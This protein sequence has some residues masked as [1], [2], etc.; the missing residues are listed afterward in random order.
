M[1][2]RFFRLVAAAALLAAASAHS[3]LPLSMP[4]EPAVAP[5]AQAAPKLRVRPTDAVST[6]ALRVQAELSPIADVEI[7]AVR[8]ENRRAR[9]KRIAVGV[10]RGADGAA[11][12]P[13]AGDL[14]WI[15]VDGGRAAQAS[16]TSPGAASLRLAI[17]LAGVPEDVEMVFFGSRVPARLEGPIRAG[18]VKDRSKP[19][20]SPV[21]EGDTQTVEF[22]VP[23][24]RDARALPLRIVSASHL[25]S[26]P[27]DKFRKDVSDI[28]RSGSCNVDITCSPLNSNPAFRNAVEAVAQ[29]LFVDGG[30]SYSCTGTL[31]ADADTTMQAPWFYSANHC[32]DEQEPPFRSRARVQQ[33]ADT[34]TTLW[35]FEAIACRSLTPS[36]Y[37]QVPGGAAV[38]HQDPAT[39]VLFLALRAAPPAGAFYSG[40]DATPMGTGT[41]VV[42]IH[43]PAGDLKKVSQGRVLGFSTPSIAEGAA[44]G[45][46]IETIW[47][48][49]TTEFGS[50][51][52][53]LLTLANGQY[54]LRGGLF[55]GSAFC[56]QP[57]G[58]DFYSR[59]D[60]VYPILAPYLAT[61][62]P[63]GTDFTDLWWNPAE[64]GWGMNLIQHPSRNIFGVWYTYR[65]DRKAIWYVIPGVTWISSNV[66]FATVYETSGPAQ[67]G[68]FDPGR[69]RVDPVGFVLFTFTDA[70]NG[71]FAYSIDGIAGTKPITRQPF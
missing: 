12:L 8:A 65:P 47:S 54:V 43:H 14:R 16:V 48:S 56:H 31:L 9:A 33:I 71:T 68:A 69:V 45:A 20:W 44:P 27:S 1:M 62:V 59:F 67:T 10:N 34:L 35:H 19:W 37:T 2:K 66:F 4:G 32:F 61:T 28:G 21:T 58:T 29:M 57:D 11:P 6:R 22:F 23:G 5:K 51:G 41:N 24:A 3:Q 30:F 49:G 52:A 18:D 46:F 60:R 55:G 26:S 38:I 7:E 25:F 36:A 40:W 64:S 50:S 13:S 63:A 42:T 17:D 70:N 15:S 53:G 39:D